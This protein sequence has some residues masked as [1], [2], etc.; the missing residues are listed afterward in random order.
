MWA[1]KPILYSTEPQAPRLR[2]VFEGDPRPG[3]KPKTRQAQILSKFKGR[4]WIDK[5]EEQWVKIDGT[6]IDTISLGFGLAGIHT[7]TQAVIELTKVNDEVWLSKR[8]RFHVDVR[9]ALLKNY[10]EDVDQ[11]FYDY[12]KFR[13]DTKITVLG[14]ANH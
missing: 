5:Q 9:L 7:G 8:V 2:W 6:A 4:V 14:E 10:N 13:A 1:P 3:F 12:K 11:T